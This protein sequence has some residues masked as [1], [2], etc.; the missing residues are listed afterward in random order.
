MGQ[1]YISRR[2]NAGGIGTSYQYMPDMSGITGFFEPN[3]IDVENGIW[4]NTIEGSDIILSDC[5]AEDN[6]VKF[7]SGSFGT[8][9]IP[10]EPE[11]IYIIF[12]KSEIGTEADDECVIGKEMDGGSAG[13]A[14]D[15]Y[16]T[17]MLGIWGSPYA[18]PNVDMTQYHIVTLVRYFTLN[19]NRQNFA[20]MY[21]DSELVGI[22]AGANKGCYSGNMYLNRTVRSGSATFKG[23]TD[24]Y[25]KM[26][27]V[28]AGQTASA[29]VRNSEY[30]L[31]KYI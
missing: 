1:C 6:A 22:L 8:L 15:L 11:I 20:L 5:I 3:G 21:V 14:F 2:G 26:I 30:L 18:K 10:D 31:K 7:P 17:P 23:I 24:L 4:H 27:A 19:T 25:I 28:G 29:I 12:K 9:P 13:W 16:S